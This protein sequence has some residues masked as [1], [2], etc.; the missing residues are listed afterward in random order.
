MSAGDSESPRDPDDWFD[1]PQPVPPRRPSRA[2]AQ[3]GPDAQTREQ[4]AP[5]VDDWLAPEP[6]RRKRRL[7]ADGVDRQLAHPH[8]Q[9]RRGLPARRSGLHS[10]AMNGRAAAGATE[11]QAV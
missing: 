1:E 8:S 9:V 7:G 5:Q 4:A 6:L 2:S 10:T 3:V 11:R